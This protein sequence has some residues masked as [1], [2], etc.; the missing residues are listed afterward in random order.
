MPTTKQ[1]SDAAHNL[2]DRMEHYHRIIAGE[3]SVF[4]SATA[5]DK[6]AIRLMRD[7]RQVES[8][9]RA[10]LDD[11]KDYAADVRNRNPFEDEN[12]WL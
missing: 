11:M 12:P 7:F 8:K 10:L 4:Y 2:A 1:A 3:A 5:G 9:L 6:K